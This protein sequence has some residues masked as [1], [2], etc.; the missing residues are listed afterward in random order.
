MFLNKLNCV[1]T[2]DFS[3]LLYFLSF[4]HILLFCF[5]ADDGSRHNAEYTIQEHLTR[6]K[7]HQIIHSWSVFF[8]FFCYCLQLS[9]KKTQS[10]NDSN[11]R[12]I[13]N[14]NKNFS[15]NGIVKLT[16]YF[17]N[18][19]QQNGYYNDNVYVFSSWKK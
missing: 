14:K 16:Q 13:S 9:L 2:G 12:I 6:I 7:S 1:F 4:T 3:N 17:D 8:L 11:S 5:V 19:K 10:I 15:K 18:D